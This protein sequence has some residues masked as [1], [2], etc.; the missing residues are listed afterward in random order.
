MSGTSGDAINPDRVARD[1]NS[2]NAGAA[3]VRSGLD[4]LAAEADGVPAPPKPAENPPPADPPPSSSTPL[5]KE[6]SDPPPADVTDHDDPPPA[7]D[8]DDA[9][10]DP[11]PVE[12]GLVEVDGKKYFY[13]PDVHAKDADA[14]PNSYPSREVA[15]TAALAKW[16]RARETVK[17]LKERNK[18]VK[19]LGL[20]ELLQDP[21]KLENLNEDDIISMDDESLR[22]FLKETDVF[23]KKGTAKLETA[24]KTTKLEEQRQQQES[25]FAEQ[26]AAA[27][28]A[29]DA[30]DIDL[31]KK[32]EKVDDFFTD[33]KASVEKAVERDL[34]TDIEELTAFEKDENKYDEMGHSAFTAELRKRTKDLEAKRAKI[35][36]EYAE[37]ADS[38]KSYTEQLGQKAKGTGD[39]AQPKLSEKE[40][41][42]LR[43][44]SLDEF[45]QDMKLT[46]QEVSKEK[47]TAFTAWAH[48]NRDAYNQLVTADDVYDAYAAYDRHLSARRAELAQKRADASDAKPPA[49]REDIKRPDPTKQ[50]VAEKTTKQELESGLDKLAEDMERAL[51]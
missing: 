41:A 16:E 7:G 37:K 22:R 18:S 45:E 31:N 35:S 32:Y 43:R 3:A 24:D 11:P 2:S 39:D 4:S 19:A 28:D 13:H 33:L 25:A 29:L 36:G 48:R 27:I 8:A 1:S 17:G 20:P 14:Y 15:E 46:D 50:L 9:S 42:K 40:A 44:S 10:G 6:E 49:S 30:L 47:M 38:I 26:E 12:A 5:K 51:N 34:R 21:D 23:T